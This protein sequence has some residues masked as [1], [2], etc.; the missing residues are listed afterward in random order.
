V[1][2]QHDGIVVPREA[3]LTQ[4][5]RSWVYVNSGG[6]ARERQVRTGEVVDEGSEI[7]AGLVNG[8]GVILPA[9]G[10][11]DGRAITVLP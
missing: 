2:E 7:L 1:P 9:S 4:G 6:R 8:E 5:T 11:A 10:L 3:V